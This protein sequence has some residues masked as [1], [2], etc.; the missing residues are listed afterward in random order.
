MNPELRMQLAAYQMDAIRTQLV[1][2]PDA[3]IRVF[4][5]RYQM[6]D[7]ILAEVLA[8]AITQ[9]AFVRV[10]HTLVLTQV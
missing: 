7:H 1:M 3:L 6:M 2:N 10:C 4:T 5:M 9:D 8:P